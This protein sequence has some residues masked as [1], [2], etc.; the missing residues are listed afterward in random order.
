MYR[1]LWLACA[2]GGLMLLTYL[3]P[4]FVERMQYALTRGRQRAEYEVAADRLSDSPL[5]EL[6]KASQLVSMRVGPSVVHINLASLP[7]RAETQGQAHGEGTRAVPPPRHYEGQ[8]SGVIMD[9]EGYIMTNR[10]VVVGS[11][12]IQVKL[13][14]GRV[15]PGR[16]VGVDR[17]TDLA[18]LKVDADNLLAAD[19][20]DS[21]RLD[22]GAMVWALGSPFGLERSITFGILSAKHRADTAGNP[23]QDFLQTDAAV[24]PGNSGGPLVD[25]HG[26]VIGINTA[27]VGESYQGISFAIPSRVARDVYDRIRRQGH[28]QRGWL[29]V[30]PEAVTQ[31][32]AR[33][34]GISEPRGALIAALA[35]NAEGS[36]AKN[37]GLRVGDVVIRWNDQPINSPADLFMRVG[38]T[39]I[40]RQVDIVVIR[41]GAEQTLAVVVGERSDS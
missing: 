21:G 8:G 32:V 27:I 36:P 35:E 2:L 12:D 4:P 16:I 20:G 11:R 34:L 37:A 6:S 3:L 33:Q 5:A 23:Y 10:H 26:R 28:V 14:D 41:D 7:R 9:A 19:W 18:V 25:S 29:G 15:V 17:L 1:F 24:N 38:M 31:A 22:V 40:G 13:G 30:Q 39:A